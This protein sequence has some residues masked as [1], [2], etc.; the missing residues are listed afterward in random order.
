MN[1]TGENTNYLEKQE[2]ICKEYGVDFEKVK[3]L[4]SQIEP[5]M[6]NITEKK[7]IANTLNEA[8]QNVNNSLQYWLEFWRLLSSE[9]TPK[10]KSLLE[11]FLYL[12]L[13]EG[14]FD[15][16]VQV[17]AFILMENHH[18]LYDPN[19]MEFINDYKKLEKLSLYVKLQFI[20][21]HGFEFVSKAF[22]R[23]LRNCI[24]HLGFVVEEDGSISI[25]KTGKKIEDLLD[26]INY[27]GCL[28]TEVIIIIN[29][30]LSEDP[31]IH[32]EKRVIKF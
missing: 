28:C 23:D 17:I 16:I 7:R 29:K 1:S 32:F 26:R 11:L 24:A 8:Y 2:A 27:L 10:R 18:D 31:T 4:H 20:E 15:E 12:E 25:R 30:I 5:L 13:S 6:R 9:V 22:D 14:I 21:L 19:G 3:G